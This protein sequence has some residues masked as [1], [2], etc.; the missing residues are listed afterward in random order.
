MREQEWRENGAKEGNEEWKGE[1][2]GKIK[3]DLSMFVYA[4][5]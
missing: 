4:G 5:K 2:E 3:R 1:E